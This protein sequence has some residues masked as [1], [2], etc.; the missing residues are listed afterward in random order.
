VPTVGTD[1][2]FVAGL[3]DLLLERAAAERGEHPARPAV[4]ELA[5]SPDR[6]PAGCCRNPRADLPAACG[7]DWAGLADTLPEGARA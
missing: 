3:V 6:C 7:A 1:P 4:G 5:P 2:R